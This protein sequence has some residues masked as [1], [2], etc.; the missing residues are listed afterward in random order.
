MSLSML[1]NS[2]HQRL[3]PL[4]HLS[5]IDCVSSLRAVLNKPR[6]VEFFERRRIPSF[7][8]STIDPADREK[9]IRIF[10][11]DELQ[12]LTKLTPYELEEEDI[13]FLSDISGGVFVAARIAIDFVAFGEV[14]N[15][16]LQ[17]LRNA[18]HI[19]G[20]DVVYRLVLDSMSQESDILGIVVL[21]FAPLQDKHW[22]TCCTSKQNLLTCY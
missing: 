16:Q 20:L 8:I 22:S 14:P 9:D 11:E 17:K 7:N 12:K 19:S 21:S 1:S 4:I 2:S 5:G 13:H 3:K 15:P 18:G 10:L 6:V